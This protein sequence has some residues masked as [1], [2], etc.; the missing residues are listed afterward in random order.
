M[1]RNERGKDGDD[2]DAANDESDNDQMERKREMSMR[3]R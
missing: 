2:S 1:I 3:T